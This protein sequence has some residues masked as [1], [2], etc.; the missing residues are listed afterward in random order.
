MKRSLLALTALSLVLAAALSG[1]GS[2]EPAVYVQQVSSLNGMSSEDRFSG[3]V[4]SENLTEVKKDSDKQ[5]AELLVK[6]GQDVKQ[7]DPLFS[8]DT[9]QLQLAADKLDL[10]R[11][12]LNS[13]LEDY[14]TQI[15]QL[16]REREKVSANKK[17]QYTIQIQSAQVSLK[18]AELNLKTKEAELEKAQNLLKNATVLSPITGR[19]QS[20]NESGTDSQGNAA[21]YIT[22]QQAGSY[23]VKGT[24]GELQQGAI[25]KGDRILLTSRVDSTKTWLGTVTLVDYEN[26]VKNDNSGGY[27]ISGNDSSNVASKYPFYVELDNMDGLIMG[28][29]LYMEKYSESGAATGVPLSSAFIAYEEDGSAYV[30]VENSHS[31]LEKRAVTLG[32]Y[33]EQTDRYDVVEGL[34]EDDYV[35]FPDDTVC[36]AGAP[37][38]HSPVNTDTANSGSMDMDAG[39]DMGTEAG[40][41]SGVEAGVEAGMEAQDETAP[42]EESADGEITDEDVQRAVDALD[43]GDLSLDDI[44]GAVTGETAG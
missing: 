34:S 32:D 24:I 15:G 5:V 4:V 18:E 29:H 10:E 38:S 22:I 17:L 3:L 8:Y 33:N 28:Q 11:E 39:L 9:D 35:A 13:S 1:C 19:V 26:P 20:I 31:K 43:N 27:V 37:T 44:A 36:H 12:Q 30:W 42:L 2:K 14:Q 7:G 6:E 21:A 41:D 16:E 23:R 40:M 25:S